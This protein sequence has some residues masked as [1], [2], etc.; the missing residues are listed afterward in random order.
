L[1]KDPVAGD[2]DQPRAQIAAGV[3]HGPSALYHDA[4]A[5]FVV[6]LQAVLVAGRRA[7]HHGLRLVI[8]NN[9]ADRVRILEVHVGHRNTPGH[10]RLPGVERSYNLGIVLLRA[11][12]MTLLPTSPV[13]PVTRILMPIRYLSPSGREAR[14]LGAI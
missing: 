1:T 9:L 4:P 11:T 14:E 3:S 5:R 8:L 7:V 2:E 6:E 10:V 13:P 12:L